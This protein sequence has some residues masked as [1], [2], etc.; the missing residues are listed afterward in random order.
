MLVLFFFFFRGPRDD[1]D[2]RPPRQPAAADL[3][4][5][6]RRSGPSEPSTNG[7]G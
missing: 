4:D 7:W 5:Q 1:V 6:W 3:D 2:G